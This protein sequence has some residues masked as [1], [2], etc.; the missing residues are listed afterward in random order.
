MRVT[1]I[2]ALARVAAEPLSRFHKAEHRAH[3]VNISLGSTV[4]RIEATN[5][6]VSEVHLVGGEVL[7]CQIAI[8]DIGIIPAIEPLREAGAA[9]SNGVD[10]DPHCRTSLPDVFAIGDCAAHANDFA[11]GA[12]VRIESVQSANDQASL[13]ARVIARKE[14]TAYH[15]V[16][17]VLVQSI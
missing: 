5:G 6:H 10:V 15:A 12:T 1:V 3:G 7:P 9:S 14:V 11:G 2:E 13:V 4:D 17:M 16:T 8:V